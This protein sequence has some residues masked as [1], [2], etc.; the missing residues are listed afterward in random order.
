MGTR[1]RAREMALQILYGLDINP[2]DP[3]TACGDL[4]GWSD[5]E[6]DSR[7]FVSDLVQGAWDRR[8]EIDQVIADASIKWDVGRMAVVD[9]NLL[10]LATY[11]MMAHRDTP[12]RVVLN[13]AIEMAKNYG[14]EESGNFINGV[15]D[16]IKYDLER[17][18]N[19][20]SS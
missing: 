4:D 16:R 18:Q 10:R 19:E 13:E 2:G 7:D 3:E 11:E 1:R 9:R 12:A 20:S 15:L 14:G 8:S 5:L 6:A 17:E